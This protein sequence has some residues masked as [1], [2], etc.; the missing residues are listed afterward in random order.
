MYRRGI[1]LYIFSS[2][3]LRLLIY[4]L[5]FHTLDLLTFGGLF[6]FLD[7]AVAIFHEALKKGHY[8]CYLEPDT[9]LP[10]MYIDDCLR[11][12]QEFMEVSSH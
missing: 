10:M 1:C 9:M 6:Q 11:S 8:Q 5:S 4:Q 3:M 2:L 7:Y 12:I